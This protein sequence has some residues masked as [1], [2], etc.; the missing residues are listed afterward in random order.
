[1]V[2]IKFVTTNSHSD[3]ERVAFA[4]TERAEKLAYVTLRPKGTADG[5]MKKMV[6]LPFTVVSLVLLSVTPCAHLPTHCRGNGAIYP[7]Q[8]HGGVSIW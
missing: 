3:A 8:V 5:V 1:M 4:R 2:S 7:C 6:L